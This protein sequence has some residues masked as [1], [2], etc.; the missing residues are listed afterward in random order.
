MFVRH[1]QRSPNIKT[2]LGQRAN[3][4]RLIPVGWIDV[5]L[6]MYLLPIQVKLEFS[7]DWISFF[8]ITGQ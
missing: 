6:M 1:P 3:A 8:I 4:S 7:A 2:F 5:Q